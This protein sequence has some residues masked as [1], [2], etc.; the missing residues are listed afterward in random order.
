MRSIVL[1]IGGNDIDNP[2][3]LRELVDAVA[4]MR[5]PNLHPIIVHGGGKEIA[6]LQQQL[7]LTP[8]FVE[9]M[10]VTDANSLRVAIMVLTG[11]VNKRL[12][13]RLVA[14]GIPALGLCGVDD[15]LI[16]VVRMEYSAG[17]LGFVGEITKV[18]TTRLT[19]LLQLDLVPVIA[20]IS[21][22]EDGQIY[23]VNAD[24]AAQGI[25]AAMCAFEIVFISN[26][27]GVLLDNEVAPRLTAAE[28]QDL[29]A[30]DVIVGGMVPKVR[31]ALSAVGAGVAAA[32]I[33]D[34]AGLR[35]GGGTVLV[36]E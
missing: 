1:K 9:G 28:V 32:R 21:L 4:Q 14:G 22:G 13:A 27:P 2:E 33:T 8:A 36:S 3:F 35:A 30:R 16:R 17:D 26:V 18:N 34:L 15:G 5:S 31:G 23:N 10:R 24:T 12:V 29:I 7:G 25:A 11:L 20:P 6:A 19:Q